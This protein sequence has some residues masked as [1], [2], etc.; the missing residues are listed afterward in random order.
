MSYRKR[1][2]WG[3]QNQ[4]GRS[5]GPTRFLKLDHWLLRTA[6]WRSLTAASRALYVEM[7]QRYNGSNNG[8]ISMS[9]REAARLIHVAKDTAAKSFNELEA[10]GFIR[11]NVCGSFDW[12]LRHATTW[13]LTEY[14]FNDRPA[15]KDFASWSPEKSETGPNAGTDCPK[16]GPPHDR[17]WRNGS[18]ID[19]GLGP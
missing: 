9:V 13:I 5:A 2:R 18:K 6:A 8:E 19:P 7:G 17:L 12:K 3:R 1:P 14:E 11:R 16:R 4:T 10:K 15:S